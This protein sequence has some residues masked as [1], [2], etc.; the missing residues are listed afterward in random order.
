M[1]QGVMLSVDSDA[2]STGELDNIQF[3]IAVARRAWLEKKN[4]AN[5]L[6]LKELLKLVAR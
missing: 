6:P 1:Q 4:V 2:H 3:G 5:C